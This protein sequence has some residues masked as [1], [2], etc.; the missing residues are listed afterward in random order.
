[1]KNI[2]IIF[3]REFAGYFNSLVA[4]VVAFVLLLMTGYYFY[5]YVYDIIKDT[6]LIIPYTLS[7]MSIIFMFT[8][9][10]MT[11]HI[12]TLEKRSGTIE[13]LFSQPVREYQIVIGKLLSTVIIYLIIII[14][15]LIYV[16]L[17]NIFGNPDNGVIMC[18][19]LGLILLITTYCSI[20]I[21]ASSISD[22]QIISAVICFG[23][24]LLFWLIGWIA[25]YF[26]KPVKEILRFFSFFEHYKNF[27]RGLFSLKDTIYFLSSIF[28]FNFITIRLME[29]RE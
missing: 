19:Y 21:L 18:G 17:V 14:I 29:R 20:G 11:M 12:F 1:M 15:T 16:L 23:I 5:V 26:N 25:I 2:Y 10:F 28:I 24:L 7:L 6:S 22:N 9:P 27:N 4:Y 13:L 3:R 8:I